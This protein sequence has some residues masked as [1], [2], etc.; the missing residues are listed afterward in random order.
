MLITV[1]SR[2]L[3]DQFAA[4]FPGFCK[5]GTDHNDKINFD[6]KGFIAVTNSVWLLQKLTFDVILVDE[7][8]HPLPVG[9]PKCKEMYQFSA[10]HTD[11]P[12]FRYRM[13]QAIED[14]VLSD[15]DITVPVISQYHAYICLGDLLLKQAGRFRRVLA[16]CNTVAEAK[17]FR[18]VLEEL[19]LA[20]WHINAHTKPKTRQAIMEEFSGE[21]QK[22]VHILVTVEVLG[23]G[24]NIPNADTCMFVQPR[25]SYRSIVQ[26][27]GRVLRHHPAKTVAHI[28]LPAAVLPKLK[29]D[30]SSSVQVGG[31]Q[32][33]GDKDRL[34]YSNVSL[35][36]L[37]QGSDT[38][39]LGTPALSMP[40]ND[41]GQFVHSSDKLDRERAKKNFNSTV[42]TF[43]RSS[44]QLME[45]E[46][47]A[48]QFQSNEEQEFISAAEVRHGNKVQALETPFWRE[49]GQGQRPVP[50]PRSR[51][52]EEQQRKEL[53][54]NSN[55]VSSVDSLKRRG[56][57]AAVNWAAR[58][59]AQLPADSSM[60]PTS[61]ISPNADTAPG[62]A[63]AQRVHGPGATQ[64]SSKGCSNTTWLQR[65]GLSTGVHILRSSRG[66]ETVQANWSISPIDKIRNGTDLATKLRYDTM[67]VGPRRKQ[68]ARLT[69]GSTA[70][71]SALN[72]K[73][74]NQLERFLE[75]LVQADHRL[76]GAA[77]GQRIQVVDCSLGLEGELGLGEYTQEVY[78]RLNVV[79]SQADPWEARFR[80]LEAFAD[81]HGR[82]PRCLGDC[83][84]AE[85]VL[86]NWLRNQ[87]SRITKQTMPA[88]KLQKWLN[89][90]SPIIRDR[91][92]SWM[93]LDIT[94]VFKWRC[95]ELK[96]YIKKNDK[97]PSPKANKRGT[98]PYRL[99][100][101]FDSLRQEARYTD[102]KR[103]KILEE[104]HPLVSDRLQKWDR[105]PLRVH[106][107]GWEDQLKK[108]VRG[109]YAHGRLPK[110]GSE[111]ASYTWLRTQIN[112][113]LSG[114]LPPELAEQLHGSHSLIAA[115][116]QHQRQFRCKSCTK[117]LAALLKLL[118]NF[119]QG[120]KHQFGLAE[121]SIGFLF[122]VCQVKTLLGGHS[123]G[124]SVWEVELK[125]LKG[126][127]VRLP[128]CRH[129]H[130]TTR[131]PKAP[132]FS[133]R[134]CLAPMQLNIAPSFTL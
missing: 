64:I 92:Q 110:M 40:D 80:E 57:D 106:R 47:A 69:F 120:G 94:R 123:E 111:R 36:S 1:P 6:A 55:L 87:G 82:L 127:M 16:Y 50:L 101:W 3:L 7:A 74:E 19:G 59:R 131:L 39:D 22:P 43:A 126:G 132:T 15:Y 91:A 76:I 112:R 109:V 85:K 89:S 9:M 125:D 5:V 77:A 115:K 66:E 97:L 107:S 117:R 46:A 28:I 30:N 58:G 78:G 31:G 114:V 134:S 100:T 104:V 38:K 116:V 98:A 2:A 128:I 103:R 56:K 73:F 63:T 54:R 44:L 99:A 84:L 48:R 71:V 108:V 124:A 93:T 67:Q 86:G 105:S 68:Q 118:S 90:T 95:E 53:T 23:E 35:A 62:T 33:V 49:Y 121:R 70:G 34:F 122:D 10:T 27:F 17:H 11:E 83:S 130:A 65:T 113:C 129:L 20:A 37:A 75:A 96:Q 45:Q 102:P 52:C 79:L 13:G 4:D 8:H 42:D 119:C 18:M 12:K 21:L 51:I 14:G 32:D 24:I 25:Q 41:G 81:E 72:K 61:V 29:S 26:A 88:H 133:V 60:R